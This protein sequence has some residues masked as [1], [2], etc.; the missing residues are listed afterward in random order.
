[1]SRPNRSLQAKYLKSRVQA[2]EAA[3]VEI[4]KNG[5]RPIAMDL[6][7]NKTF[8][9][10]REAVTKPY[11]KNNTCNQKYVPNRVE[12]TLS[13]MEGA[14]VDRGTVL[15]RKGQIVSASL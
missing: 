2:R 15:I 11:W 7:E 14:W 5:F 12:R 10:T 13:V 1:M 9:P 3:H 4:S 8:T 6:P